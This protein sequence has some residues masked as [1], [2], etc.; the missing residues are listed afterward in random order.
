MRSVLA[1]FVGGAAGTLARFALGWVVA[2]ETF[3]SPWIINIVGSFVL[4]VLVSALWTRDSTPE[5]LKAGLGTGLLGGFTTFSAITLALAGSFVQPGSSG[6]TV[7]T[8]FVV[9]AL[10]LLLGLI[11]A[12]FGLALGTQIVKRIDLPSVDAISDEGV[13]L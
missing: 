12:W 10:D 2:P 1:V 6:A 5:W 3:V 9:F 13:D 11:A 7:V 4:G 8:V